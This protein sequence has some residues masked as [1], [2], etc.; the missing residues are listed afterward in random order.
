MSLTVPSPC[1]RICRLCPHT[2]WCEGCWRTLDEITAWSRSS[3]AERRAVLARTELRRAAV[4]PDHDRGR[5]G[6]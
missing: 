5:V 4:Q 3:D 1:T 6:V 2:G